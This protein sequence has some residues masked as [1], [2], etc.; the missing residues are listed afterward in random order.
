MA[1]TALHLK[2]AEA[3]IRTAVEN[4]INF[5][6]VADAYA[7]GEAEKTVGKNHQGLST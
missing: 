1:V 3:C 6:D 7:R 4:G 2:T 5:I